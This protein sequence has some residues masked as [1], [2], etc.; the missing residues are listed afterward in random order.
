MRKIVKPAV[1]VLTLISLFVLTGCGGST[2]IARPVTTAE[3]IEPAGEITASVNGDEITVSLSTDIM[4]GASYAITVDESTGKNLYKQIY[5]KQ[6]DDINVTLPISA[7]WE[8]EV[9]VSFVCSAFD[10]GTQTNEVKAAYGDQFE[11]LAGDYVIFLPQGNSFV[12]LSDEL[13]L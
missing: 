6:G 13:T 3:L 2:A 11:N 8:G 4:D 9:Y 10:S 7:D 12:L 5:T 1:V